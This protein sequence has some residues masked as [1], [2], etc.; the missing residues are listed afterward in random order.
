M[1]VGYTPGSPEQVATDVVGGAH[2]QVVKIDVGA[3]GASALAGTSNPLP[4][5]FTNASQPLPTGAAT[6]TTLAALNTKTPTVA[7]KTMALSSPVVI[8]SD[9][10]VLPVRTAPLTGTDR[11]VTATTTSAALMGANAARTKFFIKNDS[12]VDVWINFGATAVAAAGS[13]NMKIAAGGYFEFAGSASAI[14]IIA[15]S[16]TAAITA[17]EF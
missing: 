6:E 4:V 7:Q 12:A 3:A 5:T 8:A 2:Y 15:A 9:Q 13:G 17:R 16:G 10:S 11:S 1:A 14:N